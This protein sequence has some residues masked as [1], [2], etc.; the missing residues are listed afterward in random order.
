MDYRSKISEALMEH[1]NPDVLKVIDESED[2]RGHGGYIEGRQTHFQIIIKSSIFDT[3]T[4][5][6]RERAIHKA[7]GN[8]I[9]ENIH[10][11]SIKF[12]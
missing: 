2:H 1:Y 7:L 4:R 6:S 3:M 10:A 12:L 5:L 8:D 11:I 9:I